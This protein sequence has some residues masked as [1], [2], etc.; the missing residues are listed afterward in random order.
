MHFSREDGSFHTRFILDT[1]VKESTEIYVNKQVWYPNGFTTKATDD[2]GKEYSDF[3]FVT[4][5]GENYLSVEID[6]STAMNAELDGAN[7]NITITP[8]SAA[9]FTQ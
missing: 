8:N 1:D 9:N 3:N 7:I 6:A 4:K 2:T 5:D